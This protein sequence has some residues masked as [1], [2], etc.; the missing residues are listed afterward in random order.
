[1]FKALI[2][3]GAD[4]DSTAFNGRAGLHHA[5]RR[6]DPEL[7][8]L[9]LDAGASINA[10]SCK[11][12]TPLSMAVLN[13]SHQAL[14]LLLDRWC[15]CSERPCL[16][17]SNLLE[18]IATYADVETMNILM[19]TD[20]LPIVY[21]IQDSLVD[22]TKVLRTR[23]DASE[24]LVETF[25]RLRAMIHEQDSFALHESVDSLQEAGHPMKARA[26]SNADSACFVPGSWPEEGEEVAVEET[27]E[28]ENEAL[29]EALSTILCPE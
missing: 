17:G 20:H 5:A 4:P 1:M 23:F 8:T 18:S 2:D 14:R 11:G 12:E 13:N 9:L 26:S 24:K 3:Y 25:Q 29:E 16:K 19:D 21:D 27:S 28:D 15:L 10:E 22:H 6:N 7:M